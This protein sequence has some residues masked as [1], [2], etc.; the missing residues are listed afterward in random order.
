MKAVLE[1]LDL[2]EG[3]SFL[4]RNFALPSFDAAFHFHPEFELTHI[5][6]GEGQRYVGAQ[7][8]DFYNDDL[9]FLGSNLPHCWISKTLPKGEKVEATVVQFRGDFLG[10]RFLELP[11]MLWLNDLFQKS[12][13]GLKILGETKSRVLGSLFE[14][15]KVNDYQRLVLFLGILGTLSESTE[16]E[17]MDAS[18]SN[19]QHSGTETARFQ[20]VF[21]YLI[22]HYREEITL[23]EISEVAHLSPTSFCRYFKAV[24][25]KTFLEIVNAYRIQHACQLLRKN[26]LSV[27]QIAFESGFND[28]PYFNKLFKKM[29]GV[30]PMK[31]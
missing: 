11:E 13:A 15:S 2:D 19:V 18:F 10:E 3:S 21:A 12:K 28:V 24:T 6:K 16:L 20:K 1:K 17:L 31:F 4:Y 8:E 5:R 7:V 14:M 22:E 23:Q 9:V 25:G 29:K 30:S 26:Q 27:S